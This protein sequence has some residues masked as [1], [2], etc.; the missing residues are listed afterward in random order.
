MSHTTQVSIQYH[1]LEINYLILRFTGN[2]AFEV[3]L[4]SFNEIKQ[5]FRAILDD[6]KAYEFTRGL[7]KRYLAE[8]PLS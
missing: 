8:K 2:D 1:K 4:K 5:A 6:T 7:A 3:A